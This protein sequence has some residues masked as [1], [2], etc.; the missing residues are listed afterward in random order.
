[1]QINGSRF[2]KALATVAWH[3]QLARRRVFAKSGPAHETRAGCP[4]HAGKPIGGILW[5]LVTGAFLLLVLA[6]CATTDESDMP[7]ATPASWEG[8]PFIP[9]LSD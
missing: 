2:R 6:G 3:G 8:S 7:W 4:C 9:G 1:M 5:R